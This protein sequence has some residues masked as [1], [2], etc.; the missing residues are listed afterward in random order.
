MTKVELAGALKA[1][2]QAAIQ[3]FGVANFKKTSFFGSFGSN[4][5]QSQSEAA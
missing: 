1:A 5:K 2:F 4:E 3:K